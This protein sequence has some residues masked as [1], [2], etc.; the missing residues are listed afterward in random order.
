MLGNRSEEEN[1]YAYFGPLNQAINLDCYLSTYHAESFNL[2][3]SATGD[4]LYHLKVGKNV[5][6]NCYLN[7]LALNIEPF[8]PVKASVSFNSIS[9]PFKRVKGL[10]KEDPIN[11][12]IDYGS[13]LVYGQNCLIS[14]SA[15]QF[16]GSSKSLI[17]Y[18]VVCSRSVSNSIG[19]FEP[20]RVFLESIEKELVISSND[21]TYF[22]DFSGQKIE[23]EI[24]IR[25]FSPTYGYLDSF[26]LNAGSMLVAQRYSIQAGDV[27]KIDISFKEL[28]L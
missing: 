3:M 11:L 4:N 21:F 27:A 8:K 14:A 10:R 12:P 5:Y 23:E 28:V 20:Q 26:Q 25:M 1:Q 16:V 7:S 13:S 15:N 9:S 17:N 19:T 18:S 22:I 6:K 2:L 24:K